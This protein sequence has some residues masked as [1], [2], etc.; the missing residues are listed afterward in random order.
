MDVTPVIEGGRYP[1][2]A[3]VGETFPVSAVVFREGHDALN[4]DVVLT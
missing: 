3:T 1:A 2:K 4:A